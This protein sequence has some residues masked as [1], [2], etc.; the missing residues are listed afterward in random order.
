VNLDKPL[1]LKV[2]V[3]I[4]G[5]EGLLLLGY[6]IAIAISSLSDSSRGISGATSSPFALLLVYALIAGVLALIARGLW[7]GNS[8]ARS[9]FVLSQGFG[10][11]IAQ[12][13]FQGSEEWERVLALGL[14]A[15]AVT[16]G[17]SLLSKPVRDYFV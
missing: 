9:A 12:T 15:A 8:S 3:V 13:L 1:L 14:I 4:A 6:G 2:I 11:V 10:I 5:L 16:S 7:S 17:V